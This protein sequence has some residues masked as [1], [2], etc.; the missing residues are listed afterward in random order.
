[1]GSSVTYRSRSAGYRRR[2]RTEP[3]C[4]RRPI[5]VQP[6]SL[7]RTTILPIRLSDNQAKWIIRRS[8]SSRFRGGAPASARALA[9]KIQAKG[10][11]VAKV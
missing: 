9:I 4:L 6:A 11:D 10:D 5:E 2:A 7:P 8:S 1:V 3:P